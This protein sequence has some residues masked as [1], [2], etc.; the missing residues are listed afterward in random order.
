MTSHR[1]KATNQMEE[2]RKTIR[3]PGMITTG[4]SF[5]LSYEKVNLN[6]KLIYVIFLYQMIIKVNYDEIFKLNPFEFLV[7]RNHDILRKNQNPRGRFGA[8]S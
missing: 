4:N 8:T 3:N 6:F 1:D 7:A 5:L 2:N